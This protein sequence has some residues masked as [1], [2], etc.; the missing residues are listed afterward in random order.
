MSKRKAVHRKHR[1]VSPDRRIAPTGRI[2]ATDLGALANRLTYGGSSYHKLRAN[3]YGLTPPSSPRPHKSPCDDV[4]DVPKA[5]ARRL[6]REG[7]RRGMVSALARGGVPKY[8]WAVARDGLVFEAKT[9]PPDTVYHGYRL[10]ED[11][12]DM[13]D[14]VMREWKKRK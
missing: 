7:L 1:S 12:A 14:E 9:H 10:L 13:R 11:D 3:D 8:V 5:E 4:R 2:S 6:L